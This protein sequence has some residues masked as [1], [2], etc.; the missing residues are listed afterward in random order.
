MSVVHIVH[1]VDTEG[2]LTESIEQTF[3]RL[4]DMFGLDFAPDPELLRRLQAGAVDLGGIEADVA[5]VIAPALLDYNDSWDAIR[6]ML[7]RFW[8]PENQ[9][10]LADPEGRPWIATW[11]CCDHVDYDE[12]PQRRDMGFHLVLDFYAG[13]LADRPDRLDE[14]EFH[15]HPQPLNGRANSNAT[16]WFANRPTLFQILARRI[17]DRLWFPA[18]N[19]PGF[20][21]ARPDSH[22]F[23][24]QFVPFDYAN[25]AVLPSAGGEQRDVADGRFGDWRRAPTTWRPYHPDHDDYQVP[26]RCRRAI[27]RCLNV[28]TRFRLLSQ[29]DV[30]QAFA[31]AAESGVAVLAFT[32]HDFR[33]IGPDCADALAMVRRAAAGRPDVAWRHSTAR[34]AARAALGRGEGAGPG[35]FLDLE[36]ADGAAT[37]RARRPLFGPQPFLAI[38][39]RDGAYYHDAL[40]WTGEPLA[41]RYVFDRHTL[42]LDAI[43]AVGV[44]A[45]DPDGWV[46]VARWRAAD[47]RVE[48]ARR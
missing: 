13:M 25:Q 48:R 5:R 12:N 39:A 41:W 18:V 23:L 42:P 44:G 43:E 20:H 8:A 33:D 2:P 22:W 34:E 32:N 45:A 3:R 6:A 24:E 4:R 11:H 36:V 30:D 7:D 15:F 10:R 29:E 26:G 35:D 1:C 38:K 27:F 14:I 47:G 40:D 19:R 17:I 37:I 16:H 21:V 31:E 9:K 28:G 46:S